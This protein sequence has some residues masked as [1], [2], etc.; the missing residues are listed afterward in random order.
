MTAPWKCDRCAQ[1]E[2][3]TSSLGDLRRYVL[4]DPTSA[5]D[6]C[7]AC[8]ASLPEVVRV[9]LLL[10]Q[11]AAGAA[12][13]VRGNNTTNAVVASLLYSQRDA[14]RLLG[15]GRGGR[16][17]ALIAAGLVRTVPKGTRLAVPGHEIIRLSNEGMPSLTRAAR[18]S[19]VRSPRVVRPGSLRARIQALPLD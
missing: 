17:K 19:S 2:H 13:P 5:E 6:T 8:G 1:M 10:E 14:A 4:P 9:R 7:D 15:V 12:T 18:P 16:L 11:Q 3:P